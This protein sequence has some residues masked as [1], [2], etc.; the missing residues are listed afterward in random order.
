M[1]IFMMEHWKEDVLIHYGILGM[2]WGIRRFQP[3]SVKPRGSGKSGKEIGQAKKRG[4]VRKYHDWRKDV[5]IRKSNK[6]KSIYSKSDN[7][8]VKHLANI[9]SKNKT[10][11]ANYHDRMSNLKAGKLAVNHLLFNVELARTD[12]TRLSGRTTKLGYMCLD[13][14]FTGGTVGLVKDVMYLY[15]KS[16]KK[17]NKK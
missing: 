2:K 11:L 17:E 12:T 3:Y 6:A 14:M 16:E 5:N 13:N 10:A 9:R 15:D 7:R 4:I 8:L 1:E